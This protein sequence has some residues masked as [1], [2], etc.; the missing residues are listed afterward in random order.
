MPAIQQPADP[1]RGEAYGEIGAIPG[2]MF[3]T[4]M[5]MFQSENAPNPHDVAAA[6]ASLIDTPKGIRP[7][8]TVVGQPFGADAVNDATAPVQHGV[9]DSAWPGRARHDHSI[10]PD[11]GERASPRLLFLRRL[12]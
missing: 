2:K 10:S 1:A 7:A 9:I 3:E 11:A 12:L 5:G 8:R 6:I 4:F